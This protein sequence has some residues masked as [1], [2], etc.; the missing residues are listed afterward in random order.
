MKDTV[1]IVTPDHVGLDFELAGPGSRFVAYVVDLIVMISVSVAIVLAFAGIVGGVDLA[2]G[3]DAGAT[4]VGVAILIILFFLIQWGYFVLFEWRMRGQT[5]GKRTVK[6]RVVRDDGLPVGWREILVR[7][8]VRAADMFPPPF[9]LLGFIAAMANSRGKRLGDMAAGTVVVF[10]GFD[11]A[12]LAEKAE[13]GARWIAKIERGASATAV[14]LP[15]GTLK[16]EQL[17]IVEQFVKRRFELPDDKRG[18]LAWR[19]AQSLLPLVNEDRA[20][21]EGRPDREEACVELMERV[22]AAAQDGMRSKVKETEADPAVVAQKKTEWV[23]FGTELKKLSRRRRSGLASL[24]SHEMKEL[25]NRYRGITSDLARARSLGGDR[26]TIDLLN[27]LAVAGHNLLYG[28]LRPE[29]S[30]RARSWPFVFANTVRGRIG[31]VA[32]SAAFLVG[33]ALIAYFAVQWHP[34]VGYDIVPTAFQ[35]FDPAREESMHDIPQ[36]AR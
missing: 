23:S 36:L 32:A 17:S 34:N 18:E 4:S 3:F 10:E 27:G 25:F 22:L 9:Y 30:L 33:P 13:L 24:S 15:G 28:E 20:D 1:E 8:F 5:P 31:H 35:E 6:L 16:A 11:L 14:V 26:D 19:V 12:A 21:W 7:N 29:G 2:A